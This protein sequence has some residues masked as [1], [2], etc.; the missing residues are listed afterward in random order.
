MLGSTGR[1]NSCIQWLFVIVLQLR[2]LI[3]KRSQLDWLHTRPH[4]CMQRPINGS[5][6]HFPCQL[7]VS[8]SPNYTSFKQFRILQFLARRLFDYIKKIP[9][10]GPDL[11]FGT[12]ALHAEKCKQADIGGLW[13]RV[14][15]AGVQSCMPLSLLWSSRQSNA[16]SRQS[17]ESGREQDSTR[18]SPCHWQF[19]AA[20]RHCPLK[21]R[22]NPIP[23]PV[24]GI[25]MHICR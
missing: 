20:S 7:P 6:M 10:L 8:K 3:T 17:W 9:T 1:P 25:P 11:L 4:S 5:T 14:S 12:L 21:P 23:L 19:P 2:H 15:P 22:P 18:C 13:E 16:D 24:S